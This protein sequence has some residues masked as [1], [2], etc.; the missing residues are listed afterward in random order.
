MLERI[1][2]NLGL[3]IMAVIFAG[4]LWF[5][6]YINDNPIET[7]NLIIPLSVLNEETLA[8]DNLRVLN[9]YSTVIE[10]Y[11]RGRKTDVESVIESDFLAYLDFSEIIDENTTYLNVNELNYLGERNIS[12]GFSSS[13]RIGVIIDRVV[14]GEVPI[15][16]VLNGE[17]AVGFEVVGTLLKPANY[18]AIDI[19]SLVLEVD[20]AVVEIDVNEL[21]GTETIRK[22]CTVYDEFGNVINELSNKTAVDVTVN[23]AKSIPVDVVTAGIPEKDHLVTNTE[24]LPKE[25]LITGSEEDLAKIN[26]IS[27]LPISLSGS[28]E[29]FM[30]N[31]GLVSPPSGT[32]F[33][34]TGNVEVEV[35]IEALFEKIITID[36]NDI[37]IRW[38]TPT[39]KT[40]S[41]L[42]NNYN[43][44]LK[45]RQAILDVINVNSISP[46]IDVSNAEDGQGSLPLRFQSLGSLEQISY[47]LVD[48]YVESKVSFE[49]DT[50]LITVNGTDNT[51]FTYAFQ[52]E[53]ETLEVSGLTER[54]NAVNILN[55]RMAVDATGLTAGTHEVLVNLTLPDGVV[56]IRNLEATLVVTDK[57]NE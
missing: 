19:Q 50:T 15:T 6:V 36:A 9:E 28:T 49:V 29:T 32:A 51:K 22:L 11:V 56:L 43:V 47:P 37:T 14:T 2:H 41:I 24:A 35:S 1:K 18:I 39:V 21:R 17:P 44:T 55:L 20:R 13:G 46:Y 31:A 3:K 7:R 26:S 12:F 16:V 4:I 33:V 45:G 54:I 53:T 34:G 42:K 5:V 48:I 30:A 10:I 25:V 52:S 23:I 8:S 38:G 40:Y 27:T 57:P